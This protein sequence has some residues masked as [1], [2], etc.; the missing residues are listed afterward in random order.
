MSE[1]TAKR[2]KKIEKKVKKFMK[3]VHAFLE[4]KTGGKV[5]KA[6]DCSLMLLEEY[7][8]QFL[9]FTI[10]IENLDSFIVMS[11]YGEQPNALF[12]ARDKAAV[13]LEA[14]MKQLGITFKEAAK[15]DIV[16]TQ[17]EES[18]LEA[19]VKNKIEKR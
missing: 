13:R 16:E 10:E 12:A 2:D 15:L 6:W 18:P 7:Y 9:V 19:F 4:T 1:N 14:M 3:S 17:Q 11:R 8:K 5:E